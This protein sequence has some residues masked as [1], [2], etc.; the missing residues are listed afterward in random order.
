MPNFYNFREN[1]LDYSFDDIFVPA[2]LFRD[3]N[4]WVWGNGAEGR[5]GTNDT[6]NRLTPVTTFAGGNNWKQVSSGYN[7][8]AA[9]KSDGTLW[10]WG[11]GNGGKYGGGA[12]GNAQ[13]ATATTPVTTFAGGN[14]WKQVTCGVNY[15]A[16]I[17]TDGTLWTWGNGIFGKLGGNDSES[18]STPITTFAGGNNWKQVSAGYYHTSAIKT[19]GTLWI[20]G[21]SGSGLKYGS[22]PTTI[23]SSTPVTTFAGGNNWKQVSVGFDHTSAIKTDGTL[24]TWGYP[25]GVHV[26]FRATPSTTFAGGTNWADTATGAPEEL[27]TLSAGVHYTAAIKTDGTLWIWGRATNGALGNAETAGN[28]S[29]PI[30]TFAGGTNW[31]QIS[32]SFDILSTTAAIKTDGTLWTWGNGQSGP[33]GNGYDTNR[34][35]PVTTFAGGTNWKQVSCGANHLAAIKTDGTLWTWGPTTNGRLGNNTTLSAAIVTPITTFA[36]GNNWK[37][38]SCGAEHTAAIKTDGTLWTWGNSGYGQLGNNQTTDRSSPITTFAGGTNWKQVSCG[39]YQTAAIKTDGTLWTWGNGQLG[40]LGNAQTINV[41]TPATTFAGGT[42]WKQVSFKWYHSAAIKT[43]GT[44]WTWGLGTSGQLGNY[45]LN[46]VSTPVTTFA[47]G[48]NWKQVDAGTYHTAALSDDGVNKRLYVFGNNYDYPR[49]GILESPEIPTQIM[50][51]FTNWK[52]VSAGNRHSAAIKT[53]GTLW[54]W[55]SGDKGVLGIN[56]ATNKITPVT[57]F[58]GGINWKQVF[59]G[60]KNMA[61]IKTDGTLWVWGNG[62]FGQNGIN[63]TIDKLTPVTTFAGGNNWKQVSAGP[64]LVS[65]VT[66]D[67][68]TI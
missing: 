47:G 18:Q 12:Q 40:Q 25:V 59:C 11:N 1:G 65:A 24:W 28:I 42:N 5:L 15:T 51:E 45:D 26:G 23:N 16:A 8:A 33:L 13:R 32:T 2:D 43:D 46:S 20:W 64:T 35:T 36:G 6:I 57:T 39:G 67:D 4:L 58:A 54:T 44:L 27:Y 34:S 63:N 9:V 21:G 31:K 3:G 60:N 30:T 50:G 53:D 7:H 38:V 41:L 55:G 19:D 37:Q 22:A 61:A 48:N 14:N 68:P 10:T 62:G 66:Y 17:K 56:S 29:T 49:L 52:Q